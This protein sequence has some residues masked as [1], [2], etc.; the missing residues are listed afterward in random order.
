MSQLQLAT[1]DFHGQ[2]IISYHD[3]QT[4]RVAVRP[5]C[6]NLGL[7]WKSQHRKISGH[8]IFSRSVV[9]MTTESG[10]GERNSVTLPLEMLHGWLMSI[11][12]D[13]V[14]PSIR[15]ML[16]LYQLECYKALF[17][18]WVKGSAINPRMA[19]LNHAARIADENQM[20]K[21][22]ATLKKSASPSERE[23]IEEALRDCL[24]RLNIAVPDLS[25]IGRLP[26][27]NSELTRPIFEL[28]DQLEAAGVKYNHHRNPTRLAVNLHELEEFAVTYGLPCD[29]GKRTKDALRAHPRFIDACTVNGRH[30]KSIHCWVFQ[31]SSVH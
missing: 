25:Q 15:E 11:H 14:D 24:G 23:V 2:Q 10:I 16:I 4:A 6:E 7:D 19:G 9:I 22:I 27:A 26:I 8:P 13:K 30:G 12:P 5:V 21:L 28:F 29:L 17:D 3:G 18:Y 1:I 20:L 31:A